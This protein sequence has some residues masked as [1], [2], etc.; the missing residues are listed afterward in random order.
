MAMDRGSIVFDQVS[1]PS[2]YS[3]STYPYDA[4]TY[5]LASFSNGATLQGS[6]AIIGP[7][8][9]LTAAHVVYNSTLG[10]VSNN[11]SVYAQFSA[12]GIQLTGQYVVHTFQIN[13]GNDLIPNSDSQFD[14]AIIDFAD[15]ISEFGSF[16]IQANF[17]GGQVHMTGYPA[18]SGGLQSDQTGFVQKDPI[19]SLLDYQ[20]VHPSPG[21]SGGPIW[22]DLGTSG[23]ALPYIVGVVSTEAAGVL[24]TSADVQTIQGWEISDAALL[25]TF[26]TTGNVLGARQGLTD[27]EGGANNDTISGWIGA[28]YL[29]GN[30]GDDSI[31]G[32]TGFDD[33]NGNKGND[34]IDGGLGLG[35]DWLV[36]GQ[37][38]DKITA[39]AGAN[40]VYGNLG[41]DTLLGGAGPDTLRGGQGDDSITAGPGDQFLSGDRG[42]DTIVAGS[43]H[44]IIHS[45]QG[46]GIDRIL[47]YNP[48]NDVVEL[49]LGTTYT[50]RQVGSDTVVDM[51]LGNQLI[52]VGISVSSLRPD[53]IFEG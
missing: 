41:N 17:G 27:V 34:T 11:V 53:W 38:D 22:I 50:V 13:D 12:T 19:Y 21:S 5:I 44:D 7:H 29:R 43:G 45:S 40:L 16:G 24:L 14:F 31:V 42:S 30:S 35:S 18:I 49:D 8:T 9:V 46:A 10:E 39:H 32:G 15:D 4:V 1:Q 28:D 52:L 33:I 47:N 36:G 23:S 20:T 48:T 3:V 6:G 37:G 2:G 26:T 25:S 51:G